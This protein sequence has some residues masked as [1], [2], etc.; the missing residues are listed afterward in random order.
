MW[1]NVEE[2]SSNM[3]HVL[4]TAAFLVLIALCGKKSRIQNAAIK[5]LGKMSEE[6][7]QERRTPGL[8]SKPAV[9]I[10]KSKST[11][12]SSS[13]HSAEQRTT[14]RG[15]EH[16]K[17][18]LKAKATEKKRS[19]VRAHSAKPHDRKSRRSKRSARAKGKAGGRLSSSS[20]RKKRRHLR[21][22]RKPKHPKLGTIRL[23]KKKASREKSKRKGIAPLPSDAKHTTAVTGDVDDSDSDTLKG[24]DSISNDDIGFAAAPSLSDPTMATIAKAMDSSSSTSTQTLATVKDTL[25][26]VEPKKPHLT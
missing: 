2:W 16:E 5:P 17:A 24:V 8:T 11:A 21:S 22:K 9:I 23:S 4:T 12:T 20:K 1:S 13:S 3:G 25:T 19:S 10:V 26:A 14:K 7:K 15:D 6:A 18:N